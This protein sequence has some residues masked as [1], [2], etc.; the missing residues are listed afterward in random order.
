MWVR[1]R[2]WWRAL[3]LTFVILD[4]VAMAEFLARNVEGRASIVLAFAPEGLKY[5]LRPGGEINAHGFRQADARVERTPGVQRVVVLGD[6][7]TYGLLLPYGDAWPHLMAR[8][9]GVTSTRDGVEVLDFAV[10]GYDQEQ[11]AVLAR[12]VLT[13]WKPDVLV[14]GYF[15]NDPSETLVT[16]MAGYPTW[17][18]THDPPFTLLGRTLDAVLHRHSAAFRRVQGAIAAHHYPNKEEAL[19]WAFFETHAQ[20]LVDAADTA[21]V[22]LVVLTIPAHVLSG[23]DAT[24]DERAGQWAGFCAQSEE[25]VTRAGTWFRAHGARV[26]EGLAAYRAPPAASFTQ[27]PGNPSHPSTLGQE[28]LARVALPEV[29]AAL[30]IE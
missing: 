7:V 9:L 16:R 25:S 18:A 2:R 24:C 12:E 23:P 22:P 27:S 17:V 5:V 6:S 3:L 19:D 10:P 26:A 20:R 21:R 14:Y 13:T 28:R 1:H 15:W 8:E 30:G 29:R 4:L 11:I